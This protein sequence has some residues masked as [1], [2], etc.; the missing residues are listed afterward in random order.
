MATLNS[1][2]FCF[3]SKFFF[4]RKPISIV[5]LRKILKPI[6]VLIFNLQIRNFFKKKNLV[7]V[8]QIGHKFFFRVNIR[9]NIIKS[10]Y[11]TRKIFPEVRVNFFNVFPYKNKN[12]KLERSFF[13]FCK[14]RNSSFLKKKKKFKQTRPSLQTLIIMRKLSAID[15]MNSNK[16]IIQ[17]HSYPNFCFKKYICKVQVCL[18]FLKNYC[19]IL[20]SKIN[21]S[22]N[23][24]YKLFLCKNYLIN[25]FL[26][27]PFELGYNKILSLFKLGYNFNLKLTHCIEIYK[28]SLYLLIFC[29]F[30]SIFS[31]RFSDKIFFILPRFYFNKKKK[32]KW[33]NQL[34]QKL[35]STAEKSFKIIIESNFRI[36]AYKKKDT[37]H[38]ILQ[39]FSEMLYRLPNLYVGDLTTKSINKALKNGISA[40]NIISFIKNNLHG[41]CPNIPL[42]VIEQIKIWELEKMN[43]FITEIIF[44]STSNKILIKDFKNYCEQTIVLKKKGKH[45]T[46][47]LKI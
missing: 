38:Y 44:A 30:I 11:R 26:D 35:F 10:F 22:P 41:V 37:D 16:N 13:Q 27:L 32:I 9:Q 33:K 45:L 34:P 39:Q 12:F 4:I 2:D 20:F 19:S 3:I 25:E 29:E 36:Y 6:N 7:C 21:F 43:N 17:F 14:K 1:L 28:N 46:I 15:H 8:R 23:G 47:I 31:P 40:E 42:N 5:I 24:F 18:E